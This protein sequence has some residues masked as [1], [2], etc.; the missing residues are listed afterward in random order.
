MSLILEDGTIVPNANTFVNDAEFLAYAALRGFTIPSTASERA[1][2]LIL[3]MDYL[4]SKEIKLS[5]IRVSDDQELPYPREGACVR[6]Q[7]LPSTGPKSI[8]EGIKRAQ[9]E[10]AMQAAKMEL[11]TNKVNQNI[12]EQKVGEL[13]VKYFSGGSYLDV[14]TGRADAYLRPFM[15][16]GGSKNRM[17]RI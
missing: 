10:L 14:Q 9:I 15:I 5:G 13:Q 11:L 2:F 3:G 8:P 16:N 6:D 12:E 1:V 17:M 4:F 7:I